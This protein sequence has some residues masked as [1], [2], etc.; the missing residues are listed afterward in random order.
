MFFY[1]FFYAFHKDEDGNEQDLFR[2]VQLIFSGQNGKSSD[3]S[4]PAILKI[5]QAARSV[6][7]EKHRME[8]FVRFRLTRDEIYFAAISPDF[9][10]IPLIKHHFQ[11]RYADQRWII[12][13]L[14]RDYGIYY[15]LQQ[16]EPIVLRFEG[17]KNAILET[18]TAIFAEEELAFQH[19]WGNYFSSVNINTIISIFHCYRIET[20]F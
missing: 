15:D 20:F 7:R 6:G 2:Y 3:Y 12:Y 17:G 10:V 16:V 1:Q 14:K 11:D 18:S 5:A 13:D 19:L 4:A 9:D 8:A